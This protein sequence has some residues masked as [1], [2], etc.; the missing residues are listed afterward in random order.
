MVVR[1]C[2]FLALLICG[3]VRTVRG[4]EVTEILEQVRHGTDA[5]K[6]SAVHELASL[7]V[8]S[9]AIQREVAR[10]GGIAPLSA[11]AR[12]GNAEQKQ[13]AAATLLNL[14]HHSDLLSVIETEGGKEP[15]DAFVKHG[16]QALI[17]CCQVAQSG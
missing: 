6:E 12:T 7:S 16:T 13:G 4:R 8:N 17:D 15:L 1:W 9:N 3:S 11:L 14:V 10:A 5:E 2:P